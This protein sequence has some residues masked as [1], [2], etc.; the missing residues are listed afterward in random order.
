MHGKC[1]QTS[2]WNSN[3]RHLNLRPCKRVLTMR[4]RCLCAS[5]CITWLGIDINR[6]SAKTRNRTCTTSAQD[7]V[8]SESKDKNF[9]VKKEIASAF[10][11]FPISFSNFTAWKLH[12][13]TFL[14]TYCRQLARAN[15]CNPTH[16]QPYQH[17]A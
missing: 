10:V 5:S 8:A 7:L 14:N 17:H 12:W 2:V 3:L 1:R 11:P 16:L 13:Q 15:H 9:P 6:T 4:P